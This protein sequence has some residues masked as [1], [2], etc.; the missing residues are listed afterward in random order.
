[1][2]RIAPLSTETWLGLAAGLGFLV[3]S[4]GLSTTSDVAAPGAGA[5]MFS[6][7]DPARPSD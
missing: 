3:V 4:D 7:P 6:S 1:M 2:L 5:A